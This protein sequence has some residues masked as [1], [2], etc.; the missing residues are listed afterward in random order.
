MPQMEGYAKELDGKSKVLCYDL[1]TGKKIRTYIPVDTT[2]PHIFGDLT[3]NSDG[4]IF[5]SDSKSPVIYRI[6]HNCDD[7]EMF[8]ESPNFV[9]LQGLCF[10]EL[11]GKLFIADY[12]VGIFSI[13]M[14]T[15]SLTQL[16][17]S[18]GLTLLGIDGLYYTDGQLIGV[19]NGVTPQRITELK[20][21]G[22]GD[23]IV[24]LT[25]LTANQSFLKEP[26]LGLVIG[27]DFY[28]NSNSGWDMISDEGKLESPEKLSYPVVLKVKIRQAEKE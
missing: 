1:R 15:K 16:K 22:K 10:N 3:L 8:Y 11:E 4:D 20:L 19:Q 6:D 5:I 12:S 9:S 25:V 2:R 23:K 24:K 18:S 7:I 17:Q 28:F 14:K 27:N 21:S 13:D 26:T